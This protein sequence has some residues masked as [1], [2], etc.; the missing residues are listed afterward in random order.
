MAVVASGGTEST[1]GGYKIHKFTADGTFTVTS[2]G[3]VEVLVV[4]GGGAG[5][6]GSRGGAGGAGGVAVA[7]MAVE[8][9]QGDLEPRL[10]P[11]Q[12]ETTRSKS[13]VWGLAVVGQHQEQTEE[14]AYS[15]LTEHH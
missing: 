1:S 15:I 7:M 8:V 5:G 13:E 6:A 10:L 9:V 14:I 12:A 4:A 11:P 3:D 2:A